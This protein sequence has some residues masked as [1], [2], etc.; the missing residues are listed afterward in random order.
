MELE[1]V[2]TQRAKNNYLKILDYIVNEFGGNSGENYHQRIEKL[3]KLLKS[4]PELGV[5]QSKQSGLYGIILYR[6]TTLFYTF[7]KKSICII[8]VI[9]NR[10]EK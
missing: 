2:W 10:W 7:D 6:R 4:F 5:K 8:N 1:V 9:D 3:I